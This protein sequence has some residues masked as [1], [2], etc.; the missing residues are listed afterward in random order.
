MTDA[1]WLGQL[2]RSFAALRMTTQLG[3]GL[4]FADVGAPFEAQ[5]KAVL[6][7]YMIALTVMVW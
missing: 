6:R 2:L 7:P 4:Y 5:G 1:P 3:G